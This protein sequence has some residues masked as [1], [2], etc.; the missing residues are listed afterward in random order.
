ME[1]LQPFNIKSSIR[2]YSVS[3]EDFYESIQ[4][5]TKKGDAI[6][7]DKSVYNTGHNNYMKEFFYWLENSDSNDFPGIRNL[8]VV[9]FISRKS[10]KK[11]GMRNLMLVIS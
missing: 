9:G 1:V 6:I 10:F 11:P 2:N 4:K 5:T 3:F 7:I 8:I